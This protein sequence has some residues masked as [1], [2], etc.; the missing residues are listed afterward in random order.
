[1]NITARYVTN[2]SRKT[3][4]MSLMN[5]CNWLLAD[6]LIEKQSL[7]KMWKLI[8]YKKPTQ[9]AEQIEIE[10]DMT[11]STNKARIKTV[12]K[13]WR[14]RTT[15]QWNNLPDSLRQCGNINRFKTLLK[16]HIKSRRVNDPG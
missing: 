14:W 12:G 1:M 4:A 7:I 9:I 16:N 13:G 10:Q 15:W 3:K 5:K 2:M 8:H 11:I 6:E